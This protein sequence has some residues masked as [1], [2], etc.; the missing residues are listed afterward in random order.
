MRRLF[1]IGLYFK[2]GSPVAPRDLTSHLCVAAD[3]C[4]QVVVDAIAQQQKSAD[5]ANVT[6]LAT[7]MTAVGRV[8]AAVLAGLQKVVRLDNSDSLKGQV[9]YALVRMYEK[10]LAQLEAVSQEKALEESAGPTTD[11][12]TTSV[13]AK[14]KSRGGPPRVNIKDIP[15]LNALASLLSGI[16]KQLDP[17]QIP[18]KDL[19]EG[20]LFCILSK[21]GNRIYT[22]NF[23]RP[24]AADIMDELEA[25]SSSD[26]ETETASSSPPIPKTTPAVRQA[27]LEAPYLLHLLK[28]ALALTPSFL[29]TTASSSSTSSNRA[30]KTKTNPKP[31]SITK[32]ILSLAAKE[33][34]QATLVGAIFGSESI[35]EESELFVESLRMPVAVAGGGL[36][37]V[38]RVKEVEVGEWFQGEVWRLLGWEVLG[39]EMDGRMRGGK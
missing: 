15:T 4:A 39:R 1:Q 24:R 14:P 7:T 29:N 23:L 2:P 28:Q 32:S 11:P 19:F 35:D 16:L 8:V 30:A 5:S 13:T 26:A 18:H 6:D 34:L 21:L 10:I 38:P 31:G 12:K 9:T 20:F 22:I 37:T 3:E 36:V 27:Q 33:R 17:K 25:T